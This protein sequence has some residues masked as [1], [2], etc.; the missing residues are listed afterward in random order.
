MVHLHARPPPSVHPLQP[1][2]AARDHPLSAL[3]PP[4]SA[5]RRTQKQDRGQDSGMS[6]DHK[7]RP[8][9]RA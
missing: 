3:P 1:T 7:A 5:T 6:R 4:P 8:S 2:R 9:T